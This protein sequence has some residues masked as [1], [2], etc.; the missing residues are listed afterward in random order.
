MSGV[1]TRLHED[2]VSA[3]QPDLDGTAGRRRLIR[4]RRGRRGRQRQRDHSKA[5]WRPRKAFPCL[6]IAALKGAGMSPSNTPYLVASRGY[7][8]STHTPEPRRVHTRARY[9]PGMLGRN[10]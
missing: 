6:W 3:A 8:K 4:R 10:P 5:E 2:A 1:E 7:L 9:S